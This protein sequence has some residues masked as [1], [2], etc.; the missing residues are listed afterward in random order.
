ML[1]TINDKIRRGF[2]ASA[3]QYDLYSN[4]HRGIADKLWARVTKE[5][6]PSALLD[7]GC[8]TGYLTGMLKDHYPQ[9]KVIGLDFAKEMIAVAH[10]KRE[11][12]VWVLGDSHDLPFSD[13]HFGMVV[14]NLAYQWASD[15]T[16]VFIEARR[17]LVPDGVL[18]CTLFGFNTCQELFRSL[19]DVKS[20]MLQFTRL[21]DEAQVREALIVSGFN[22]PHV[23]S[24]QIK[25]EFKDMHGLIAWLKSIGANKLL[26]EGYIGKQAMARA[27]AIYRDRFACQQG[28]AA[29]FE[30]IQAYAKR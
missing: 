13:G 27:A 23:D 20:G 17:V 21:P 16:K 9:S 18:A 29:T 7:V 11:D 8:G 10:S 6:K 19:D 25:V 24:E 30:V 28:V 5:P 15:L 1:P 26:R 4:L 12:I 2:S 14:S 3:R 22:D